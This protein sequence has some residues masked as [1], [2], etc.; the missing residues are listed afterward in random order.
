LH[1]NCFTE[2]LIILNYSYLDSIQKKLTGYQFTTPCKGN[3]VTYPKQH[4]SFY[5]YYGNVIKQT[6]YP[7]KS[8]RCDPI[9]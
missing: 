9:I 8:M 6:H 5:P 2:R 7:Y 3:Q 4:K 1:L